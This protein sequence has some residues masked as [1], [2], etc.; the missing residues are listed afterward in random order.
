MAEEEVNVVT[1]KT[2]W[3]KDKKQRKE[4]VTK[5]SMTWNERRNVI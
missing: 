2:G 1:G 5:N 3:N 4:E